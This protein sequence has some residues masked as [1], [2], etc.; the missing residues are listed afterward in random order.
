M[1][2]RSSVPLFS[3]LSILIVPS[4][5]STIHFAIESPNP[6]PFFLDVYKRQNEYRN[7]SRFLLEV[8][9]DLIEGTDVIKSEN[10]EKEL[11][12]TGMKKMYDPY[13]HV[14]K[15]T[16]NLFKQNNNFSDISLSPGDKIEHNAWGIGTVVGIEGSGDD[17]KITAAFPEIGIKK[18]M[19]GIAKFK[20]I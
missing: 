14:A 20:K 4:K 3:I 17:A 13:K 12:N 5:L 9:N 11:L 15:K 7:P 2:F 16:E 19:A 1:L 8:P 18:F 6:L 10:K